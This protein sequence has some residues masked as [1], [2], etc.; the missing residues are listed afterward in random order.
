MRALLDDLAPRAVINCAVFQPVD[1][2]EERRREAFEVN[3]AAAGGVAETCAA[4]GVPLFHLSTDYV[5]DGSRREPWPEDACPRPLSVYAASKLAGEHLVLAASQAHRVV[6]TAAVF[7]APSPDHGNPPFVDRMLERARS[8]EAT[9]VVDDQVVSPTWNRHLASTL[10]ELVDCDA[11]GV[12]HVVNRGRA[13]WY[14]V[15]EV[16]F[17]RVGRPDLLSRT[18]SDEFGAPARRPA[19]SVLDTG[20]LREQGIEELPRWRQALDTYLGEQYPELFG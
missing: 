17:E 14:Q 19:F 11:A 3:A 18:T 1:L 15:A 20:R 10:W 12:F 2:C 5:F 7:G 16:V 4:R 6:R 9:R 8:G 13:S